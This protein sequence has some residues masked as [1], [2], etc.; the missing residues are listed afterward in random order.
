[1][2][3]FVNFILIAT[4]VITGLLG[5]SNFLYDCQ[6]SKTEYDDSDAYAPAITSHTE[7]YNKGLLFISI[8]VIAYVGYRKFNKKE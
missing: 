3:K 5:T 2:R 4:I 8:A 6:H 1:M 7:Y